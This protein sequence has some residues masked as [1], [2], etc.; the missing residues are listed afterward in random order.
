MLLK[1]N[2]LKSDEEIYGLK[3]H[4][5]N[6]FRINYIDLIKNIILKSDKVINNYRI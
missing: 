3:K 1:I 6:I 4:K 2:F 5:L